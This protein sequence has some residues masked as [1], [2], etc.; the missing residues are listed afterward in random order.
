MSSPS[1]TLAWTLRPVRRDDAA[2]MARFVDSLDA[3]ARRM[4]FHG[5]VAACGEALR[6]HLTEACGLR[7]VAFVACAGDEIV[8]EAR[9]VVDAAGDGEFAIAVAG[10]WQGRGVAA[11][12]MEELS[13]RA[14]RAGIGR[15]WG[16]VLDDNARM[17]AFMR[18]QGY[19]V[20]IGD[21][22]A[23]P[24]GC[25]RWE[26]QT[27]RRVFARGARAHG[28]PGGLLPRLGDWVARAVGVS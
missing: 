9:Y 21:L 26:R 25:L 28:R 4:R 18:R 19:S 8:G 6:R 5:A 7:H 2:A 10:G 27:R 15:L 17:A 16:D 3:A 23:A 20:V 22:M 12:L 13:A 11:G 24:G 1:E 14:T